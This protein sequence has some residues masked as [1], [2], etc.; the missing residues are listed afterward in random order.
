MVGEFWKAP[1]F[2]EFDKIFVG[3]IE[4]MEL[5]HPRGVHR[6]DM[7]YTVQSLEHTARAFFGGNIYHLHILL[8]T[9]GRGFAEGRRRLSDIL[10][11]GV[12]KGE[13]A[14][15]PLSK[16]T[17]F[18]R[19]IVTGCIY[20]LPHI[21]KINK[22]IEKSQKGTLR[23]IEAFSYILEPRR[24]F[25]PGHSIKNLKGLYKG[26]IFLDSCACLFFHL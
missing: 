22:S 23:H 16:I 10:Y 3:I 18:Q 20:I 15:R 5:A 12:L 21:T 1:F 11:Q 17:Q 7:A 8:N 24:V 13:A 19:K 2:P 4:E 25:Y 14:F 26:L 6:S 9:E